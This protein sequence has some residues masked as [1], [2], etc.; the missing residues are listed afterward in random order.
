MTG[1]KEMLQQFMNIHSS[2]LKPIKDKNLLEIYNNLKK[3]ENKKK[4]GD[5]IQ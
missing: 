3:L 4:N 2:Y 5:C 1:I